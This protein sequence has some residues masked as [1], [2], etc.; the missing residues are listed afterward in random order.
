M[1]AKHIDTDPFKKNINSI[2][3]GA[4]VY[5]SEKL[6]GTSF[7]YGRVLETKEIKYTGIKKLLAKMFKWPTEETSWAYL[8]GSRNVVLEQRLDPNSGYYGTKGFRFSATRDIILDKGEVIYGELVGFTENGRSIM[9]THSTSALKDK[10][11]QKTY[12][13]VMTYTYGVNTT[14]E[15][16]L[17]VYRIT[18]VNE[19]GKVTE[20]SWPQVVLRCTEL[21]LKTVPFIE[22]FIYD[23]DQEKLSER[24]SAL[25]DSP[26]GE[27]PYPSR[28]DQRHI[29]EG[30]VV[31]YESEFGTGW[32][33]SK[34]YVFG[35]L[36]GYLKESDDFVD[37]EEIS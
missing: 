16:H 6:H 18:K 32:L 29:S 14:N 17:Y 22:K 30:V 4:V 12:G 5:V 24:I 10:A 13:E 15:C 36:E 37:P 28:L 35:L 31:R 26:D 27:L 34:S 33:K 20:L 7:R 9:D 1:F 11:F 23:G 3:D 2:P 19:D 21:G 8:N 25:T